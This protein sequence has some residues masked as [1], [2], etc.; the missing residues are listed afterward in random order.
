MINNVNF[1]YLFLILLY[2]TQGH[3]NDINS[4]QKAVYSIKFH[5]NIP[6]VF[7]FFQKF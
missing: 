3:I 5:I 6:A 7:A 2:S 4:I 1:Y